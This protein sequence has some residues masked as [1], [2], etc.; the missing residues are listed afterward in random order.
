[1]ACALPVI[2]AAA[3]GA[4]NLV[5]DG[6]SGVLVEPGDSDAMADANVPDAT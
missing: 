5:N 1:M 6:V 3:T 2:A 4:T